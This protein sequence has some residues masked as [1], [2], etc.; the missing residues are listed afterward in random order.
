MRGGPGEVPL[1]VPKVVLW[2][3]LAL[4]EGGLHLRSPSGGAQITWGGGSLNF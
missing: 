2:E 3:P 1:G 4:V